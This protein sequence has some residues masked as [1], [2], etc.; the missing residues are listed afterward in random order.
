MGETI[1]FTPLHPPDYEFIATQRNSYST[2]VKITDPDGLKDALSDTLAGQMDTREYTQRD[3]YP[4]REWTLLLGFTTYG[5][6]DDDPFGGADYH[7]VS[8]TGPENMSDVF[9][10]V[11]EYT[12]PFVVWMCTVEGWPHA[13]ELD[14][15]KQDLFRVEADAGTVTVERLTVGIVDREPAGFG[16]ADE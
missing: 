12:E 13:A 3:E 15:R 7:N 5:R 10:T 9:R 1:R 8:N 11:S 14:G 6:D 16:D 4:G 2:G